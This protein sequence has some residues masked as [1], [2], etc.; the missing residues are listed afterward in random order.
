MQLTVD[1]LPKTRAPRKRQAKNK[2]ATKSAEEVEAGIHHVAACKRQSL[3]KELVNASPQPHVTPAIPHN[4]SETHDFSEEEDS[5]SMADNASHKLPSESTLDV[6]MTDGNIGS[7]PDPMGEPACQVKKTVVQAKKKGDQ[8][9][10][11]VKP[12][13]EGLTELDNELTPFKK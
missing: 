6:P 4:P 2:N 5:G 3:N 13:E 10:Q 7:L 1:L 12:R 11:A 9:K 8:M